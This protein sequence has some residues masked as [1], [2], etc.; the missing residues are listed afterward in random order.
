MMVFSPVIT[1]NVINTVPDNSQLNYY[2]KYEN[3]ISISGTG[4]LTKVNSTH[5][6]IKIY[7]L[8]IIFYESAFQPEPLT[9]IPSSIDDLPETVWLQ[10]DWELQDSNVIKL[11]EESQSY[12]SVNIKDYNAVYGDKE[13]WLHCYELLSVD[14]QIHEVKYF[15]RTGFLA[16]LNHPEIIIQFKEANF[17]YYERVVTQTT[18]DDI[19]IP[20]EFTH[21]LSDL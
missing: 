10:P 21:Q 9:S 8:G 16:F 18:E 1:G 5:L 13:I 4:I 14:N 20:D 6:N 2:C 12:I 15:H 17:K 11:V 3:S 7:V 19:I